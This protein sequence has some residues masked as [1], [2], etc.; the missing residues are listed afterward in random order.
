MYRAMENVYENFILSGRTI[1][2]YSVGIVVH[3]C[4]MAY[5]ETI[6]CYRTISAHNSKN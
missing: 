6:N 1:P 5:C 3:I 2:T 4:K